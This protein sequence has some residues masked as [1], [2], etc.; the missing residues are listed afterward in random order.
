MV[1]S[2]SGCVRISGLI[3]MMAWVAQPALGQ[4]P[5]AKR[6]G[7]PAA[8]KGAAKAVPLAAAPGDDPDVPRWLKN[9]DKE[10]FLGARASHVAAL[11]GVED[12][13]KHPDLRLKA[14]QLRD[15]QN[16]VGVNANPTTWTEIGP[17]PIPNGQTETT[18][19]SVSGRVTAIEIDPVAHN[20]IYL[21]TA[22]GGLWRSLDGGTSWTAIFETAASMAIGALA[23][24]PSDRTILYVGTGEP[25]GSADSFSG[26]GL[27]RIESANT[28]AVLHGPINPIRSY[29]AGDGTTAVNNPCF[30]GRSISKILV[31]PTDPATVF[32][33]VAGGIIGMGGDAAFGG[34]IPPLAMRGLYRSTNATAAPAA[35]TFTKL[36]VTLGGAGFDTPNTGNRN[37][38]DIVF[39][40]PADPTV[41]VAWMN[42]TTAANDG[43]VFRCTSATTSIACTQTL[44][45][46]TASARGIFAGY[47]QALAPTNVIY[48]ATGEART[49]TL[50]ASTTSAGVVRVSTDGGATWSAKLGGGGGFCGGQCFYNIGVDVRPGASAATSDDVLYLGG[51][52][53]SGTTPICSLLLGKS[54]DGAATSFVSSATGLHA[55]TH[56][57]KVDPTDPTIV[58][59][60]NDG[61]VYK[62]TDSGVTWTS[63]NVFPLSAAQY[64]SVSVHPLNSN[65]TIGG[66]QDNGTHM[67]TAAATWNRIDF[68]D[69]GYARID[70]SATDTTTV[71]MYH[72]YFNQTNGL[73]GFGRV[74][75]TACASEGQWSFKGIYGGTVDS[76]TAYC[77]GTVGDTFNGIS[78][79][80]AVNFYAPIEVGPGSPNTVYFGSNKLYRSADRGE[81]MPAVSQTLTTIRTIG[82][83]PLNDDFRL[84][85]LNAGSVYGTTTGSS[86]LTNFTTNLPTPLKQVLRVAFDPTD[87]TGNTAY[88][89]L[90]GYWGNANGHVWKTTNLASG[91]PTWT[92][93]SGT[94]LTSIP[95]VPVNSVVVDPL[96]AAHVY[97]GTDIGVYYSSDAGA[98]WNPLGTSLPRSPV[99]EMAFTPGDTSTRVLRIATHGRGM[100][101]LTPPLPVVLTGFTV[102]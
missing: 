83:S 40:D 36:A 65:Y 91:T 10:A 4:A 17:Y 19:L 69:G 86:T 71:T 78:I 39:P 64:Q 98:T 56:F 38:D 20:T 57:I 48:V 23:L 89:A 7:P 32:V 49:G 21:G 76:T 90:G 72:T 99:F 68:G 101:D 8:S 37:V 28:T 6:S 3:T 84:V 55:D 50:C 74:K 29:V 102:E 70:Q 77:D 30:N 44:Q 15:K 96:N 11:R 58:Y 2:L 31:H 85:G 60:G 52:V 93:A 62:S 53:T 43:G 26:V 46:T 27:Y 35:V 92:A 97:A 80:D 45:T 5:Q 63:L 47:K 22:N 14:L 88:V 75:T 42:G 81:T 94:G 16:A 18:T 1:R 9:V 54:T 13:L 51:N 34:A 59:H 95:D 41:L 100:W 87:S 24:A 12:L 82:I 66:T 33:G 73:L 79:S 25:N 61:G 67:Y